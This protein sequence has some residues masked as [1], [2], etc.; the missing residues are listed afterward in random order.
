M[1]ALLYLL[2]LVL[3]G[4]GAF[5]WGGRPERLGAMAVVAASVLTPLVQGSFSDPEYGVIA[6]DGAL[7]L[8]LLW[9]A[10]FSERYWPMPAAAFHLV[11][12]SVHLTKILDPT[13]WWQAYLHA[14]AF[15]A[16]PVLLALALGAWLEGPR[17]GRRQKRT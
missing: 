7:L 15:W 14:N 11:G 9:L 10:L 17:G 2:A 12:M 5:R 8:V 4:V 16:Y 13:V 3:A 6:V 1:L